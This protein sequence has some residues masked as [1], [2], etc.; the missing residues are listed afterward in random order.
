[1]D[2]LDARPAPICPLLSSDNVVTLVRDPKMSSGS[3]VIAVDS[4]CRLD[5]DVKLPKDVGHDPANGKSVSKL[6][7]NAE[8]RRSYLERRCCRQS[9]EFVNLRGCPIRL[10][11]M[12]GPQGTIVVY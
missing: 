5:K 10:A 2:R 1:M 8:Q 4:M 7:T 11:R 9:V 12:Q 3:D 6:F